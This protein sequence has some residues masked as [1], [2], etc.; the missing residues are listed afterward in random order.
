MSQV[1]QN[2]QPKVCAEEIVQTVLCGPQI[3]VQNKDCPAPVVAE[4]VV[5][6]GAAVKG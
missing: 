5:A 6:E 1:K 3:C 2:C 4:G